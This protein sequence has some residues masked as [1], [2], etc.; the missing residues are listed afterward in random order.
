M[1]QTIDQQVAETTPGTDLVAAVLRVLSTSPEPLTVS[2]IRSKLPAPY[3]SASL[4]ELADTLQRQV[5]ANVL[6]QYPKYR[7]QQ[8]RFWD[9][10]MEVHLTALFREVLAEGPLGWAELRR[11]LPAYAVDPLSRAEAV[12][13]QLMAE[14]TVHRHP[15]G[16]KRG[17]DR[18]ALQP[19]DA[20][21]YLRSELAQVFRA[22]EQLGFSEAQLR[23]AALDLLHDEEWSLTAAPERSQRSSRAE[24]QDE[25]HAEG[26]A[27]PT[28]SS[29]TEEARRTPHVPHAETHENFSAAAAHATPEHEQ[30]RQPS[31]AESHQP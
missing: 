26:A 11:K 6:H 14:Q 8:D 1:T 7:S 28:P 12:L 3:R 9:R 21:E 18:F 17:G 5:T 25:P 20:K 16:G 2:K 13:A 23:S 22:L 29:P 10:P 19:P 15:R 30:A 24:T 31:P 4:E 27:A